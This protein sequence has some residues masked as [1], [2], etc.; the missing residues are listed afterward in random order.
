MPVKLYEIK[1]SEIAQIKP[2]W[3]K[4]NSIHYRDSIYFQEYYQ[5]FTFE[6]R[7]RSLLDLPDD[8]LKIW[9]LSDSKNPV[10][11]CIA[12]IK[13]QVGEIDSIFVD[14]E[15]QGAGYGNLLVKK[16]IAWLKAN[17]C[18]KILV[19]VADG[20][21]SVFPFYMKLGFYPRLTYLQLREQ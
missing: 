8:R 14:E 6:E 21:E 2:L 1:K 12:S 3:E 9:I 15:F 10:G 18:K 20:H 7:C 13:D 16:C 4:L 19:A 5:H 17:Q 11:Y